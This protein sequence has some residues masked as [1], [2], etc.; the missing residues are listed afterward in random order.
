MIG[1]ALDLLLIGLLVGALIFGVRLERRL[2]YLR[3]TQGG[4][5]GA[6]AELNMA[7]ARA[8]RGLQEIRAIAGDAQSVL[9]DRLQDG[10]AAAARL[11]QK[12]KDAQA[13]A[14]RL[15][16]I[17]AVRERPAAPRAPESPPPRAERPPA[18]APE[19]RF[20]PLHR[21]RRPPEPARAEEELTLDTPLQLR[22]AALSR[23]GAEASPPL[24]RS[25]DDE[26]F[27]PARGGA[28]R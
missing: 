12:I 16:R 8:E 6:A 17:S 23:R 1:V 10:R 11:D 15:E 14:E 2:R 5:A 9:A 27:V 24:R 28:R 7:I 25:S 20:G 18:P 4:F 13:A 19:E 21:L 22:P 3:E 26:L